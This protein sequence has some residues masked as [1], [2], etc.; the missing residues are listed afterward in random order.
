MESR[1]VLIEGR[2]VL[3]EVLVTAQHPRGVD[4]STAC[5][6]LRCSI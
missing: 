4:M 2:I 5:R 3:R 6:W 1:P